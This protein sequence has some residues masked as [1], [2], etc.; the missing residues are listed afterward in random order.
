MAAAKTLLLYASDDSCDVE[1]LTSRFRGPAVH[2]A[3]ISIYTPEPQRILTASILSIN[4]LC[5][6]I[7]FT[8]FRSLTVSQLHFLGF[9]SASYPPRAGRILSIHRFR[10][11]CSCARQPRARLGTFWTIHSRSVLL[12]DE[13]RMGLPRRY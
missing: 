5:R 12:L 9:Y 13:D 6:N 1:A 11:S 8:F 3:L 4:L 2:L 7:L 10:C